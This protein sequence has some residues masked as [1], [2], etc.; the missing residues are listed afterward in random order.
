VRVPTASIAPSLKFISVTF[1]NSYLLKT[2]DFPVTKTR[3]FKC[4][5]GKTSLFI[6]TIIN[7]LGK[8]LELYIVRTIIH[9]YKQRLKDL[10]INRISNTGDFFTCD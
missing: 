6:V 8:N 10:N 2:Q 5:L 3:A 4:C 9:V 1:K 7:I